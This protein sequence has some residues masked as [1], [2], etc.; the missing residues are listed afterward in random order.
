MDILLKSFITQQVCNN[1]QQDGEPLTPRGDNGKPR[2]NEELQTRQWSEKTIRKEKRYRAVRRFELLRK[3]LAVVNILIICRS[4]DIRTGLSTK[5][6]DVVVTPRV[7]EE[8]GSQLWMAVRPNFVCAGSKAL[9]LRQALRCWV[10]RPGGGGDCL[11]SLG[12]E[13][14]W[15]W[16]H[17]RD[18]HS[19]WI[20][21]DHHKKSVFNWIIFQ[22]PIYSRITMALMEDTGWWVEIFFFFLDSLWRHIKST[23]PGI[24]QITPSLRSLSGER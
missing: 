14:L 15:E 13:T 23:S 2:L 5:E 21:N 17:D 11:D 20:I 6:V 18:S 22:N 24:S 12:E 3:K 1:P 10:R 9:W 7:R 19:G 4:P 16:G 8:V